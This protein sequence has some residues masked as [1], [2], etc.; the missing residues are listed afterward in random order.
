MSGFRRLT[1]HDSSRALLPIIEI[2]HDKSPPT[3]V[4]YYVVGC[5]DAGLA[6][7][8]LRS[9]PA[10]LSQEPKGLAYRQNLLGRSQVLPNVRFGRTFGSGFTELVRGSVNHYTKRYVTL[11]NLS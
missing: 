9:Q 10:W 11:S 6:A 3:P 1:R 4:S 8:L 2:V 5:A 7:L